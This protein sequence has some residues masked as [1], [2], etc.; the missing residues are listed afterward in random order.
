MSI[1]KEIQAVAIG[2]V[3]V[4]TPSSNGPSNQFRLPTRQTFFS[5]V[6]CKGASK[7]INYLH[8]SIHKASCLKIDGAYNI[9]LIQVFVLDGHFTV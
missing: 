6:Q 7:G 2:I 4:L 5:L 3:I 8:A 9:V 1:S